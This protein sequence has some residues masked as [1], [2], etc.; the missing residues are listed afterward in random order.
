MERRLIVI[1][2]LSK[3]T[4]AFEPIL[5]FFCSCQ[6][7]HATF[8][9]NRPLQMPPPPPTQPNLKVCAPLLFKRWTKFYSIKSS[10]LKFSKDQ[11]II[12]YKGATLQLQRILFPVSYYTLIRKNKIMLQYLSAISRRMLCTDSSYASSNPFKSGQSSKHSQI[13]QRNFRG[14]FPCF[15]NSRSTE[16]LILLTRKTQ[17]PQKQDEFDSDSDV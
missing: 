11:T 5:F 12:I 3:E 9:P 2:S 13:T 6:G 15:C 7:A 10:Y 4:R 8:P 17:P 14:F 1:S 16:K